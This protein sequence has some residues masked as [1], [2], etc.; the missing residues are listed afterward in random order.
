[1]TSFVVNALRSDAVDTNN[2]RHVLN[3]QAC[4]GITAWRRTSTVYKRL[5]LTMPNDVES[6]ELGTF[7]SRANAAKLSAV[8][9]SW[10]YPTESPLLVS[11]SFL[12]LV[13]MTDHAVVMMVMAVGKDSWN[14][15]T[16]WFRA[17]VSAQITGQQQVPL[18]PG[19][20]EHSVGPFFVYVTSPVVPTTAK[21]CVALAA[22]TLCAAWKP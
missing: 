10:L 20:T 1:L 4:Q 3:T 11:H 17:L 19:S 6:L 14:C 7:S 16:S 8:A 22:I 13:G 5:E 9:G 12:L 21:M 18:R 15:E 2:S